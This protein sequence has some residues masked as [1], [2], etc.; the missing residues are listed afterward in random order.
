MLLRKI[1]ESFLPEDAKQNKIDL[2]FIQRGDAKSFVDQHYL[3]KFPAS[4][5]EYIGIF[6]QTDQDQDTQLSLPFQNLV[7]VIIYGSPS[8]PNILPSLFRPLEAEEAQKVGKE[9]GEMPF[10]MKSVRELQRLFIKD[11]P[12]DIRKGLAVMAISRGNRIME[13]KYGEQLKI[14]V[15]YSDPDVHQGTVYKASNA[16]FLGRGKPS[17]MLKIGDRLIRI[18]R[19]KPEELKQGQIITLSGKDKYVWLVG[20]KSNKKYVSKFLKQ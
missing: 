10:E 2:K 9:E 6:Y 13:Q 12:E 3:G 11:L 8:S 14:L 19:A 18:G 17:K 4:P 15:S 5:T 20:S 7:G 16:M 1:V